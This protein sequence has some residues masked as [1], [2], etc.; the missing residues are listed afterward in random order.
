MV[1]I[2][3]DV[4]KKERVMIARVY[5][6]NGEEFTLVPPPGWTAGAEALAIRIEQKGLAKRV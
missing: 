1:C 2:K 5:R 4:A 6:E 3:G